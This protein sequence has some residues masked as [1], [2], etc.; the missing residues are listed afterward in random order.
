MKSFVDVLYVQF[1]IKMVI[2]F[3]DLKGEESILK[4]KIN[5]LKYMFDFMG[6]LFFK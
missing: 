4:W 5:L 1:D 3:E 2:I 6:I